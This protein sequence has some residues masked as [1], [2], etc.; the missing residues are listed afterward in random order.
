MSLLSLSRYVEGILKRRPNGVDTITIRSDGKWDSKSPC[1]SDRAQVNG[2]PFSGNTYDNGVD[3]NIIHR[4]AS[5]FNAPGRPS[6]LLH[7]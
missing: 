5:P 2:N 1:G 7:Q 4:S 3:D 6:R